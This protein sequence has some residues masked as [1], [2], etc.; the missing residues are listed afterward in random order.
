MA[1]EKIT[2]R[3][4]MTD[5]DINNDQIAAV[6]VSDTTQ[7]VTGTTKKLHPVT[8]GV[9]LGLQTKAEIAASPSSGT[10]IT[11]TRDSVYGSIDTPETGNITSDT[12]GA[13]SMVTVLILHQAG[14][15]PT[16][17]ANF[18]HI[19]GTY[20]PA[21]VNRILCTYIDDNTIDYSISQPSA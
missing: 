21:K 11:F 13:Q 9:A 17:P 10:L 2:Q 6:D 7:G 20:D 3:P 18:V 8:L 1:N 16:Y 15:E 4:Q 5:V 12:V 19:S 14:S